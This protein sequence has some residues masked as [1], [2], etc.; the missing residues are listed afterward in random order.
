MTF[1]KRIRHSFVAAALLFG[2]VGK[3]S[4]QGTSPTKES[5]A[6]LPTV[7]Q[8]FDKSLQATGGL[9]AWKQLT[10]LHLKGNISISPDGIEGTTESFSKAPNKFSECMKARNGYFWCR[11]YDGLDGWQDD[12][13][14]GLQPL[15]GEAFDKVERDADFYAEVNNRT[16]YA[17]LKVVRAEVFDGQTAYVIEAQRKDG[18]KLELYYAKDSGFQI[19]RKEFGAPSRETTIVHLKDYRQLASPP[20]KIA[21]ASRIETNSKTTRITVEEIDANS[22]IADWVFAKPEKSLRD[23]RE[24]GKEGHPDNGKVSDGVYH[25]DFFG[26]SYTLP[27]G[28]VVASEDTQQAMEEVGRR[29]VFGTETDQ[30]H[31]YERR[32][33]YHLFTAT[34]F[35]FGTPSKSN[36]SVQLIAENMAF[37]PG[38]QSGKDYIL[39]M[40][41]NTSGQTAR[42]QFLP[43]YDGDPTEQ[44]INGLVFS[45]Q[46][47]ALKINAVPVYE[48]MY[49]TKLKTFI[50]YFVFSGGAKQGVEEAVRSILTFHQLAPASQKP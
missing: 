30:M 9:E 10:S 17:T 14:N 35:P 34:E 43:Q 16:K 24:S 28:W 11:R 40:R 1:T 2:G 18:S 46:D 6:P 39:T 37:A 19:G 32:R 27:S 29:A 23:S 22:E 47:L 25:N 41:E 15:R 48:T 20:I 38:I 44:T 26:I 3:S 13:R 33:S 31:V 12:S 50:V 42:S 49:A 7:S 45:R 21:T 8:I 5:A 36:R 4:A